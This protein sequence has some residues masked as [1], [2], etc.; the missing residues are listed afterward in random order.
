MNKDYLPSKK[1]TS[2]ELTKLGVTYSVNDSCVDEL[3]DFLM[4]RKYNSTILDSKFVY[5]LPFSTSFTACGMYNYVWQKCQDKREREI[6]DQIAK[7]YREGHGKALSN[8]PQTKSFEKS[9]N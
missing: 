3:G 2:E 6:F 8:D 4:C 5:N 7:V 1:Y 9:S